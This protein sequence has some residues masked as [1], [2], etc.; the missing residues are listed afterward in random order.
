[1]RRH[2][3][4]HEV[5]CATYL[6][7]WEIAG[8]TYLRTCGL[9]DLHACHMQYVHAW[10]VYGSQ[11]WHTWVQPYGTRCIDVGY[12]WGVPSWHPWHILV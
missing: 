3:G 11:A 1:M 6:R 5:A 9:C 12:S 8:A 4:A 7:I 2:L 10:C